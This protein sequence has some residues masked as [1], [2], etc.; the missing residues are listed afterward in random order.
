MDT[1]ADP[2]PMAAPE[3]VPEAGPSSRRV[4][5]LVWFLTR[6]LISDWPSAFDQTPSPAIAR[7][8]EAF[9]AAVDVIASL[10]SF[11]R[12]SSAPA[13]FHYGGA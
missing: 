2:E 11:A 5:S 13:A 12:V 8:V 9:E 7:R 4:S 10:A 1:S 6:L 3:P